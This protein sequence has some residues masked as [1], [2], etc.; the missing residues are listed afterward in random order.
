MSDDQT[1]Q[2]IDE[3]AV[4]A[5]YQANIEGATGPLSFEKLPGGPIATEIRDIPRGEGIGHIEAPRGEAF[6][7]IRSNGTNMPE[8]HKMRA[9][10]F[11]NIP[12]FRPRVKGETISDAVLIFAV[13]DPCYSCT[14]RMAVLDPS[15]KPFMTG[16]DLIKLSHEKTEKLRRES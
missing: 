13:I 14:E 15:G 16:Q 12:S 3:V 6:H 9:P 4:T 5:W 10:T 11:L 2:G 8:R 1:I 7:Y